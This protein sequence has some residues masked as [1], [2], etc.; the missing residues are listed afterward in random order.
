MR[1]YSKILQISLKNSFAYIKDFIISNL[2]MIVIILVYVLLWKSIYSSKINIEFSFKEMIWYLIVNEIVVLSNSQVFKEVERDIKSGAIA[3]H[4]NKPYNYPTF[5][6]FDT[7]GKNITS[8]FINLVLGGI[9]GMAFVG[10]ISSLKVQNIPFMLVNIILGIILNLIIYILISL[11]SFW[12]EENR[13]F[14]W[15]YRQFV[16]AFG[17]FLAPITLF[18]KA[19][20]NITLHMPW[21]YVAYHTARSCVKFSFEGFLTTA[22]WQIGYIL[23][24]GGLTLLVFRKGAKVLNVNGG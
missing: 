22:L 15:V 11:S 9:L 24:F 5:M 6:F 21:T 3:Y 19:I 13:P 18:P 8:L 20:Y 7:M 12:V 23:L 4:L 14:I 2:F 10:G 17:G 1:K 16:F